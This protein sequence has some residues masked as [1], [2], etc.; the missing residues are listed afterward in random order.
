MQPCYVVA[1]PS[2]VAPLSRVGV[3]SNDTAVE[4]E[5]V[6]DAAALVSTTLSM[7]IILRKA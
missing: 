7:K 1:V 2:S 4:V 5:R 3:P 6:L